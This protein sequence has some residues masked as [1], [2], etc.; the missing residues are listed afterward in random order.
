MLPEGIVVL[1]S[2]SCHDLRQKPSSP[3]Q[4][5]A[6]SPVKEKKKKKWGKNLETA[7]MIVSAF[8]GM[9]HIVWRTRVVRFIGSLCLSWSSMIVQL[10]LFNLWRTEIWWK[11]FLSMKSKRI[12]P[13]EITIDFHPVVQA[14]FASMSKWKS[15]FLV[16]HVN[17]RLELCL[18]RNFNIFLASQ[19]LWV[20]LNLWR[21][22]I[23][24]LCGSVMLVLLK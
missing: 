7:Q 1:W 18:W 19:Y 9:L 4:T 8:N 11:W 2:I 21:V 17:D 22:F 20:K 10:Y 3:L 12:W 6:Y 14:V 13:H 16:A 5:E 23:L 15:A 24:Y